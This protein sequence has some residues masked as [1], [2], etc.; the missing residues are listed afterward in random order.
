[1][2]S[3]QSSAQNTASTPCA[4]AAVLL[5]CFPYDQGPAQ[6]GHH[7]RHC[8]WSTEATAMQWLMLAEHSLCA[9]QVLR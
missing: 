8:G 1:M 7:G 9:C 2:K 4:V 5:I 3:A 6:S